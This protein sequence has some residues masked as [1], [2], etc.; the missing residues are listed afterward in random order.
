MGLYTIQPKYLHNK[1]RKN[2]HVPLPLNEICHDSIGIYNL[3]IHQLL[4]E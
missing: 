1:L 2:F 4:G 3:S